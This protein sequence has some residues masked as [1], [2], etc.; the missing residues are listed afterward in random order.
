LNAHPHVDFSGKIALVHNGIIDNYKE[1]KEWLKNNE[2]E[3][4]SETDTEIIAQL[5]GLYYNKGMTFKEAVAK[6]LNNHLV[7][8]YALVIMNKDHPDTLIAARSGSPLLVGAGEGFFIVSSDVAAFQ[9]YTNN[10]FTI[11][12]QDIV[13]INLDMKVNYEKIKKT[14]L[15][16]IYIKPKDG[17]DHFMLQEIF[18]QPDTINKAMNYGSRFKPLNNK[19]TGVK[20]GGLEQNEHFLKMGKNLV[21]VSCG[22]SYYASLFVSNLM[23]KLSIFNT[24]QVVDGAEFTVDYIPEENPIMLFVSQSGE[25]FDILRPVIIIYI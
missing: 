9:K 24:V 2:I 8:S 21:I 12:N 20:L 6:T 3:V 11:E 10:Y 19:A 25:T 22:T 15:E 7:G 16:E 1:L 4:K 13:E 5:I 23:R 14:Q 18:E 17:F